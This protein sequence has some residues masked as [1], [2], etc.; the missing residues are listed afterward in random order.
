MDLNELKTAI[1]WWQGCEYL[2]PVTCRQN[3][4]HPVLRP[5]IEGEHLILVCPTCGWRLWEFAGHIF[6]QTY[7][8]RLIDQKLEAEAG[9]FAPSGRNSEQ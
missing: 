3:P 6:L 4:D 5:E 7:K 9:D 2:H 1:E 8:R